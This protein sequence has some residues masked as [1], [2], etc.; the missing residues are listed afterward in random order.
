MSNLEPT[1][2]RREEDRR[3][4]KRVAP[5][6]IRTQP[7][8]GIDYV[9]HPAFAGVRF[10][11]GSPSPALREAIDRVESWMGPLPGEYARRGDCM[12]RAWSA[13]D[14]LLDRLR[15]EVAPRL[16]PIFLGRLAGHLAQEIERSVTDRWQRFHG[17]ARPE[18]ELGQRLVARGVAPLRVDEAEIASLRAMADAYREDIE[19]KRGARKPNGNLIERRRGVPARDTLFFEAVRAVLERRGVFEAAGQVT[20]FSMELAYVVVYLNEADEI[21]WDRHGYRDLGLPAPRTGGIHADGGVATIKG[22]LYL[23]PV[24]IDQGPFC[25]VPGSHRWAMSAWEFATAKAVANALARSYCDPRTREYDRGL[26]HAAGRAAFAALPRCLRR[27]VNYGDDLLG[28]DPVAQTLLAEEIAFT[29]ER[30]NLVVFDGNAG[31]H[32]GGYVRDGERYALQLLL[33]PVDARGRLL[34]AFMDNYAG[35]T[36]PWLRRFRGRIR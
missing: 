23:G 24:G 30:A 7:F 9:H 26:A 12:E 22:L 35:L 6:A 18:T 20:G 8:T 31:S 25:Y 14:R 1:R 5:G 10:H 17:P 32:R 36:E 3:R 4:L 2:E 15:A 21:R 29:D 34:P 28:G 16:D 33:K 13:I 19:R 27:V 11:H